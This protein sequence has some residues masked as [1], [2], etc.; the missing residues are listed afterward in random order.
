MPPFFLIGDKEKDVY[1]QG[2][3]ILKMNRKSVTL[4][5]VIQKVAEPAR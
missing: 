1:F 5:S 4:S 3:Q 2:N